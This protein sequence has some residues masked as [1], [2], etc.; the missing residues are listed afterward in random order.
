MQ[1]A[2]S[3]PAGRVHSIG[4]MGD[5]SWWFPVLAAVLLAL[6]AVIPYL[7]IRRHRSV[8]LSYRRSDSAEQTRGIAS[9]LGHRFRVF[10]D[11]HSILPGQDFRYRIVS[12]LRR[13]DAAIVIIGPGWVSP[14][15][16][17]REDVVRAEVRIALNSGA[18]VMPLLVDGA[19][20]P[21]RADLPPDLRSL[22]DRNAVPFDPQN[23]D[24]LIQSVLESSVRQT[25]LLLFLPRL[26]VLLFALLSYFNWGLLAEEFTAALGIVAPMTVAIAAVSLLAWLNRTNPT[27]I[28]HVSPAQLFVP[29]LLAML[30]EGII[31]LKTFNVGFVS[32]VENFKWLLLAA[33]SVS[34]IYNGLALAS[35]FDNRPPS[36]SSV[37]DL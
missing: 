2:L 9:L 12:T 34:S 8:F 31:I 11:I 3:F 7:R 13:C 32:Y 35:L 22:L 20:L 4:V 24:P 21:A 36:I 17:E 6:P 29:A 5:S 28:Q 37:S 33:E 30:L 27:R 25:P 14:R 16:H 1:P 10:H 19:K 23:V 26:G 18:L 15:L